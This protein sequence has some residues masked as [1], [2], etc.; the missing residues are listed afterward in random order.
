MT[1]FITLK[2]FLELAKDKPDYIHIRAHDKKPDRFV[3]EF[4]QDRGE[5]GYKMEKLRVAMHLSNVCNHTS[6]DQEVLKCA[7][8]DLSTFIHVIREIIDRTVRCN[9]YGQYIPYK[10]YAQRDTPFTQTARVRTHVLLDGIP[11][12]E[13]RICDITKYYNNGIGIVLNLSRIVKHRESMA[14]LVPSVD[15]MELVTHTPKPS[16]VDQDAIR[17]LRMLRRTK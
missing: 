14:L 12:I 4:R 3:I 6:A 15:I 7:D 2:D 11:M 17:Y 1:T 16:Y 9:T 8:Q 10:I 13:P 5:G